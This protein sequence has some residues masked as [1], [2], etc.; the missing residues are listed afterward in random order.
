MNGFKAQG[1]TKPTAMG[2]LLQSSCYGSTI[3]T[4]YGQTQS[5]LLAIWAANVRE[6]DSGKKGKSSSKKGTATYVENIDFLLG[7]TPIMGVLQVQNNGTNYPVNF[8]SQS[9]AAAGGRA[10]FEVTDS[11]FYM[12]IAVTLEVAYS[13]ACDDYGAT[14]KST[15]SGTYEVPLWNELETGPDPT[16]PASY[17]NWPYCYRWQPSYGATIQ[18]DAEAFPSGTLHIYYAQLVKATKY[19]PP[20]TKLRLVFESEL[21]SGTEY[22]DAGSTYAAQQIKYPMY[23][24]AGSSDID[25]GSS[26]A[27]PQ[28]QPEVRGKWGIYPSCDCDFADIIEDIFKSG[29]AQAAIGSDTATTQTE[30]GLSSYDLPGLIQKKVDSSST[31]ALSSMLYDM[32]NTAGNPLVVAVSASGDLTISSSAG[33]T[34]NALYT[35][36]L[37]YQVWTATA[38]GGQNTIS[39][40]GASTPWSIALMEVGG[41]GGVDNVYATPR[42][43][44]PGEYIAFGAS[45]NFGLED[46]SAKSGNHGLM[47]TELVA[48]PVLPAGATIIAAYLYVVDHNSK[49]YGDGYINLLPGGWT[50]AGEYS[51][52]GVRC[53]VNGTVG[54]EGLAGWAAYV[55]S[56]TACLAVIYTLPGTVESDSS[57]VLASGTYMP[58][59]LLSIPFYDADAPVD[60]KVAKWD[61]ETPTNLHG[62][63]PSAFQIHSRIVRSSGSYSFASPGNATQTALLSFS[64]SQPSSY[65]RPLGDFI[66]LPSLDLMR[67]QCRANGLW[68]SVSMTSQSSASDWL[69]SLYSA[70]D[71][72]PVYLGSKLFSFPYSEVSTAGN[73]ATYTAPTASGPVADLDADN[74]DF[75]GDDGTPKLTTASRI[76]QDNVLSMQCISREANYAQITVRQPDAASIALYGLREGD[77][78]VNNAVQDA[79][80]ARSLLGIQ[81]RRNQYGGDTWEFTVSPRW[82]LLAP[83]DLITITDRVQGLVRLPVR[84]TAFNEQKDGGFEATAEPFVYGMCAPTALSTTTPTT[85]SNSTTE[86]A[87]NVNAPVILE[88]TSALSGHTSQSQL[89]I[90]VSS[91]AK[92]Y[93]GCQVYIS[94]D[95][96]ASYNAA[97]DPLVGSAT[98]GAT[99]ADWPAAADPDTANDLALDL[100]ESLGTLLSYLASDEDK[101]LYPCY[102]A[103]GGSYSIPYELMTYATATLTATN[104]YTLKATGTGNKLRRGVLGAPTA[105]VG[106]DHPSGS[107]FVFLSP[108]GTGILKLDMAAAWVG[109]E[110]HIK[111]CSFN[112]FGSAAQS[113]SDVT[114]Y[115]YTPGGASGTTGSG[116]VFQVNGN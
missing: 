73:G 45:Q 18:I 82:G 115:T 111:I 12:V 16:G 17:R 53:E 50:V 33:E 61:L 87:G 37:G 1:T 60:S 30:R 108:A 49:A 25:L 76:N 57:A 11:H 110:L 21:G 106:V 26:G 89:W 97:G 38:I 86:S 23:A 90:A 3:P 42:P 4:I 92:N 105:G 71:A 112:S 28:L 40:S 19:Q 81:V 79:T 91:A 68:G 24:G 94:T 14:G 46:S 48:A 109:V 9:F 75:V 47:D 96:G 95:G 64:S 66:D 63:T 62:K 98:T 7:H 101:A 52:L 69:K 13:L 114:D 84:I 10:S 5:S 35:S 77:A 85:N 27:I 104:K 20:L 51:K 80:V 78:T 58:E 36:G 67:K 34:W 100:S 102:V 43:L 65:P 22:S 83:M 72:A 70:A 107:R 8:T 41:V 113:L 103:G 59:F 29:L 55:I 54:W 88:P 32:P 56:Q 99:T 74:G 44:A 31:A 6:G 93:G 15:L 39:I 116:S 2:T